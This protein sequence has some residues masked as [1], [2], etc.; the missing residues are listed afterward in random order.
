MTSR[1]LVAG[2]GNIFFTDDGFGCEVVR[3][4]A[5][6]PLPEGVTV[7]DF[8][9]KGV[10]LAYELLEGYDVAILVDAAPCGGKP[11]D[12]YLIEPALEEI[13]ESPLVQ[14]ASEGESALVD[15]HGLEPDAIFGMLK[16]L[17]GNIGRALVV[18]CEPES[19]EDGIGL[20]ET[21]EAA[22]GPAV[23]RLIDIVTRIQ[24]SQELALST[25]AKKEPK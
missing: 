4:L 24:A 20:T 17:G 21:V 13:E 23:A 7:A 22:V 3:R 8:G 11:G 2:V 9:I 19:T 6:E 16:A 1:I 10:H 5:S 14:A 12:L 18:G 15:A 25:L